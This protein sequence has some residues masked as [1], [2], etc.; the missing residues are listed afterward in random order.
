MLVVVVVVGEDCDLC[1]VNL[2][3]RRDEEDDG[4]CIY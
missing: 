3:L 1:F 2:K 4:R